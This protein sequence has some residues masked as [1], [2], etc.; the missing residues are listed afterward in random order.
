MP[1]LFFGD[2]S[3]MNI[4]E[5]NSFTKM[6]KQTAKTIPTPKAIL[7][8]SAHWVDTETMLSTTD[9]AETIYDF[10]G[11][12]DALYKVSYP[13]KGSELLAH[14]L[15]GITVTNRGL[16]HGAW[17]I[18]THMYPRA[19]I[20]TMQLSI[21]SI[22]SLTE[23]YELGKQLASLRKHG[24]LIIGSGGITHNL[25]YFDFTHRDAKAIDSA[26]LFD[27]FVKESIEKNDFKAL[28]SPDKSGIPIR[29]VHPTLEHYIPL[30][31]IAGIL[32]EGEKHSFI[33]EGFQNAAFSMRSWKIG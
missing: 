33:Y 30:L 28:L 7:V 15:N 17:S 21:N 5:D 10:G 22:L 23:H 3:P 14:T 4:I 8:I 2:G 16:D 1:A 24:V 9:T 12:P 19:N 11:F 31:Y 13:V 6:L 25:G 29:D 32:T 20:P 27:N 18:L 26:I